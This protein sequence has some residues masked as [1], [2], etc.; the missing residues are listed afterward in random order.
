VRAS[1]S[2]PIPERLRRTFVR[3]QNQRFHLP[4]SLMGRAMAYAL[5][6]W[7]MLK[8]FLRDGRI[9]VDN[10]FCENAIRP[11]AVGKKNWLFIGGGGCRVAQRRDLLDH[12]ELLQP[13]HR[14]LRI[15]PRRAHAPA[16]D[17]QPAHHGDHACGLGGGEEGG[18]PRGGPSDDRSRCVKVAAPG[19]AKM[20]GPWPEALGLTL[21]LLFARI[22]GD[23]R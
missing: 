13:G 1:R 19:P 20:T 18:R 10:N 23:S 11:T 14:S 6:Q 15:P 7:P 21:V 17:D 8:A 3:L 2:R 9:E 5:G 12:H 16:V 22:T 4:K